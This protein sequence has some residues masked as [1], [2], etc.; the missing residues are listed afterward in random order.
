MGLL[1]WNDTDTSDFT[2][3]ELEEWERAKK[4]IKDEEEIMESTNSYLKYINKF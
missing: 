3:E 2:K 1:K 4:K